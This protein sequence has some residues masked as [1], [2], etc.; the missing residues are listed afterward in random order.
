[1]WVVVVD[2][3]GV[4]AWRVRGR[5][6]IGAVLAASSPILENPEAVRIEVSKLCG[7]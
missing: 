2:W 3:G 6:I 4:V 5:G 7:G 1:V